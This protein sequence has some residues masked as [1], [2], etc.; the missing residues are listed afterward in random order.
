MDNDI[1]NKLIKERFNKLAQLQKNAPPNVSLYANDFKPTHDIKDILITYQ[2]SS[3]DTLD[4]LHIEVK[5][6]GRMMLRRIMGRASFANILDHSGTIQLFVTQ[7]NLAKDIYNEHFK[8]WDIGDIIGV[9]GVLFRTKTKE[10]SIRVS[11]VRLLTK[12]LRP[13]PEKFHGLENQELRYRMRYVDLI[14]NEK[15][16]ALFRCRSAIISYIRNFFKTHNFLEVETPMMHNISGGANARPFVT[17]HNSLGINLFLRIAPELYLKRLIVGGF[18][19]VFEINRNFR[20]EGLSTRH[21]PE[22]TMIEFYESYA[23]FKDFILL[24]EELL[25]GLVKKICTTEIINY[26]G[27]QLDFSK[28]FTKMTML[29]A[30]LAFN[31]SLTTKD[32]TEKNIRTTA[33]KLAIS[34]PNTW[35]EGKIKLE[36]FEKTVEEKLIQPTFITDYPAEV[37]PLARRNDLDKTI[38]ERFE[39]FIAGCEIANAFSELNDAKEQK[40][41]FLKQAKEKESGDTE[42]MHY[43]S[44]YIRALEY[45]MPPTAGEGI[46]IDRVVMLLTNSASIRD[47]LLF[48]YMRPEAKI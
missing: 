2:E 15:T 23:T 40:N 37:S 18:N 30:I 9:T 46:G 47:V 4:A 45:G 38:A 17:H 24:S 8:K 36:I 28:P 10:L 22:F 19:K 39:L 26:Q 35:S 5:I 6:A 20:N 43:D 34:I 42:A 25:R 3:S 16:R 31:P 41:C 7:A 21:N 48:P 27:M 44:D 14:M 11:S 33:K 32:L 29:D 1:N 12:S 13:L